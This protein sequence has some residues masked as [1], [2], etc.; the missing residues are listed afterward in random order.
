MD[1][2]EIILELLGNYYK[3]KK[4]FIPPRG[5]GNGLP[6][7]FI[8]F[9]YHILEQVGQKLVDEDVEH[10]STRK[11]SSVDTRHTLSSSLGS[12]FISHNIINVQQ[13]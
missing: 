3:K 8:D 1:R 12:R 2:E 4:F 9:Y 11:Q 6:K 13:Q 10:Q 7:A 5:A